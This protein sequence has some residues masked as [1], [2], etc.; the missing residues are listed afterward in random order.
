M[1]SLESWLNGQIIHGPEVDDLHAVTNYQPD[2]YVN[3]ALDLFAKCSCPWN[4]QCRH[5]PDIYY[6]TI[7]IISAGLDA[8]ECT[9]QGT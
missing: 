6:S 9:A 5:I 4:S 2:N 8:A 3:R 1:Y 7:S